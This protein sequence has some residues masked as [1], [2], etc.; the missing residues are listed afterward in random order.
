MSLVFLLLVGA[1]GLDSSNYDY[2]SSPFEK[3][4]IEISSD[5][6][7][8]SQSK[9]GSYQQ[10]SMLDIR[11]DGDFGSDFL[12]AKSGLGHSEKAVSSRAASSMSASALAMPAASPME[13][14]PMAASP[15]SASAS[16]I[17]ASTSPMSASEVVIQY[18]DS[19]CEHSERKVNEWREGLYYKEWKCTH[20]K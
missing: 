6:F 18:F 11:G 5:S 16:F 14:S 9:Q 17:E 1:S 13:I 19:G 12:E 7:V 10:D 20:P 4:S 3:Q 8:G 15:V 2:R